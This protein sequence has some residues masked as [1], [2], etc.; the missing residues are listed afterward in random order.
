MRALKKI[1][2]GIE[3][4]S[5]W[6]G[7]IASWFLVLLML[8]ISYEVAMRYIFIKPTTWGYELSMMFGGS[9]LLMLAYVQKHDANIRVGI[10]YEKFSPRGRALVNALGT[11]IFAYPVFGYILIGA[12]QYMIRAYVTDE[13]MAE[14]FWYPPA[15]PFRTVIFIAVCLAVLQ[16]TATLIRDIHILL[17]GE[18]L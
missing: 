7:K 5:T 12:Y 1:V 11:V 10:L 16:F 6:T 13:K 14:A 17:K 3:A 9:I 15:A 8:L 2:Y 4:V 18:S